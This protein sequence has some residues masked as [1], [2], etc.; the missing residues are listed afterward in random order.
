VSA[1]AFLQVGGGAAVARSPFATSAAAAGAAIDVVDGWE[2]PVGFGDLAEER[3]AVQE[4]VGFADRSSLGKLELQGTLGELLDGAALGG[5]VQRDDAVWCPLSAGRAIALCEA[6]ATASLR[7]RLEE[8]WDGSVLDVTATFAALT[9]AGP[10]ARET[11][12]RFCALDLRDSATPV[13]A[14][15]PGSVAR[16]PGMVL[17]EAD[18]RWLMLFGAAYA[19]YVWTVVA[20]AAGRLGG[21]PVG[22]GALDA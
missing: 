20:D 3:R 18:D 11:F 2:V 21:R 5:T 1:L 4:T 19:E 7:A 16:T 14:F 10:L 6:G 12:A 8:T 15:R 9:I 17:R 22:L 13:G